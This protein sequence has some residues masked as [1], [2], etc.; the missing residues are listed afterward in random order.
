MIHRRVPGLWGAFLV[1]LFMIASLAGFPLTPQAP[2]SGAIG[3]E[4]IDVPQTHEIALLSRKTDSDE[5]S[6][7]LRLSSAEPSPP[8]AA[9]GAPV[10]LSLPLPRCARSIAPNHLIRRRCNWSARGPPMH[11]AFA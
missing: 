7:G 6:S 3:G 11:R 5:G 1:A 9:A 4:Q 2:L 8:P 10:S